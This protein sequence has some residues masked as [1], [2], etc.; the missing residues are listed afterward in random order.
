M[1]LGKKEEAL[2]EE[3]K[4]PETPEKDEVSH[5]RKR[6]CRWVVCFHEWPSPD[7]LVRGNVD[8]RRRR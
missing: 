7:R 8:V 3:L 2:L 5:G 1:K 4:L 6:H